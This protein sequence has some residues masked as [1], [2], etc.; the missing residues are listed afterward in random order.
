LIINKTRDSPSPKTLEVIGIAAVTVNGYIARHSREKILWSKDLPLFKKQTKNC[1][2]IM[3]SN[4]HKTLSDGLPGREMIIVNRTD[5]PVDILRRIDQKRC[6]VIG[7]GKTYSKFSS[8]LTHLYLTIHPLVFKRGIR[9][10][11]KLEKEISIS[12]VRLVPVIA[13]EGIFQ[14]QFKVE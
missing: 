3:G 9:L 13:E 5:N 14:F 8:Y 1:A 11:T 6:F 2:V 10:F 12:F 7:G 4:T